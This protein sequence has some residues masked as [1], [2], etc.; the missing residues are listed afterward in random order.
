MLRCVRKCGQIIILRGN[1]AH[2][3]ARV[4]P[5]SAKL[6]QGKDNAGPPVLYERTCNYYVR[7]SNLIGVGKLLSTRGSLLHYI[8]II[9]RI[10]APGEQI[11]SATFLFCAAS[12]EFSLHIAHVR[13]SLIHFEYLHLKKKKN[14]CTWKKFKSW[15]CIRI[16]LFQWCTYYWE[17]FR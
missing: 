10:V 14:F 7:R 12:F 15:F 4:T 13:R 2:T 3:H 16:H 17:D 1:I 9:S 5:S 11:D 6:M 8:K